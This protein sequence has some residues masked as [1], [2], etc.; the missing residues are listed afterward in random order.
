MKVD[1][2]EA[3]KYLR[4]WQEILRFQDWDI[5][6]HI[7]DTQWRKTGDIKI[8][9]DNRNAILMLNGHNPKRLNIEG[10]VI[11]ELMHLRLWDMD[12]MIEELIITVFGQ[13]ESNPGYNFA[14]GKFM[15]TLERTT[16][17]I[18]RSFLQ[19]K[20]ENK[21]ISYGKLEVQVKEEVKNNRV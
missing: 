11:H 9:R 7:V 12:Q 8:D 18:S 21:E 2:K 10:V 17:E 16:E 14:Y 19:L 20:G 15:E 4:K 5:K 13:D 6:L 1:V 3:E